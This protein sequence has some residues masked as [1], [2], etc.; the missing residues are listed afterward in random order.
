MYL[1]FIFI[2]KK[3]I[4]K[5]L[6]FLCTNAFPYGLECG[7]T[8][9]KA[10]GI[11]SSPGYPSI[12]LKPYTCEWRI[13]TNP[14][15]VIVLTT[16]KFYTRSNRN[17]EH[18]FVEIRNGYGPN[19]TLIGRYC[20]SNKPPR[21]L[22]STGNRLLVKMMKKR[23]SQG[24]PPGKLFLFSYKGN[25]QTQLQTIRSSRNKNRIII[26][27]SFLAACGGVIKL[28]RGEIQSPNYPSSYKYNKLCNWKIIVKEVSSIYF[29]E[30][31]K[32][33]IKNSRRQ[34]YVKATFNPKKF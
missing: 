29:G 8:L 16:K 28:D 33:F 25:V 4:P 12:D 5:I 32:F 22:R 26:L 3:L 19:S 20:R 18:D 11:I 10:S 17:C 14:G 27:L 9:Q 6:T 15:E 24:M 34:I 7:G 30:R 2:S 1:F 31:K 23:S 21:E 13:S